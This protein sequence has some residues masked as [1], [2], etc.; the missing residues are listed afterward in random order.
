MSRHFQTEAACLD[1]LLWE[2]TGRLE[3]VRE[4]SLAKDEEVEPLIVCTSLLRLAL[5]H[6]RAVN[7]LLHEEFTESVAPLERAIYEIWT[8][9]RYLVRTG[10]RVENARRLMIN[11]TFEFTDYVLQHRRS[12]SPE[13][14]RA[15]LR[16]LRSYKNDY[17]ELYT[18]VQTQR[19]VKR[20]HWSGISRSA[21]IRQLTPGSIY[22][23][24]LSWEAHVVLSPIRDIAFSEEKDSIRVNFQPLQDMGEQNEWQAWTV[25]AMIYYF[26]NEY[27]CVFGLEEIVVDDEEA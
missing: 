26:W 8:D 6:G 3:R 9:F 4:I 22:Y 16:G 20:F 18:A 2:I 24:S 15:C 1:W 14:V 19:R 5:S 23:R 11:S 7:L 17:P 12:F 25:G 13:A 21:I 10:N 27:A